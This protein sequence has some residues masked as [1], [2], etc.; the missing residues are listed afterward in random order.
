MRVEAEADLVDLLLQ[1][2]GCSLLEQ[3]S[4]AGQIGR[5]KHFPLRKHELKDRVLRHPG[6]IDE[7]V[8]DVLVCPERQ[9]L[10]H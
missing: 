3:G 4:N 6:P 8:E 9:D 1:L 10:S 7:I 5:I 2:I